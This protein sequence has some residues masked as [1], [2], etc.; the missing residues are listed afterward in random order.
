M[1]I[2]CVGSH[3]GEGFMYIGLKVTIWKATMEME[4]PSLE[5][6]LQIPW[7]YAQNFE[8]EISSNNIIHGGSISNT[9]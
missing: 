5:K 1:F 7:K 9:A 8:V 2:V 4:V 3:Y 6:S